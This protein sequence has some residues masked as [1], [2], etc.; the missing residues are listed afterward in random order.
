MQLSLTGADILLYTTPQAHQS[1][2]KQS[3]ISRRL[4]HEHGRERAK[5]RRGGPRRC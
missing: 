4:E 1:H 3:R 5:K 2:Q